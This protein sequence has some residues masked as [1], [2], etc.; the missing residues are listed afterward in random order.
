MK[1]F[2]WLTIF[3]ALIL[4]G[5]GKDD[6]PEVVPQIPDVETTSY[7]VSMHG[8]LAVDGNKIVNKN[9]TPV[10]FAG[11]SFFWSNDGWGGEYYYKASVVSW[12]KK[13]W[14]STIV[15]VAMGVDDDGGYLKNKAA[16]L[17]RVKTIVDAAI[18]ED[19]YVIIDWHSH[20]AENYSSDAVAFFKEMATLY[21]KKENVIYE[22][23]NEP[24]DISWSNVIKPYAEKIIAAIRAI[25][26]D[27]LIIV[28]TPVWSQKVDDAASDPITKYSNIAYTLHFYSINHK[29]WLR[30]RASAALSKGIALFVTE[31]GAVGYT[32]N[33]PES[34]LW[35]KWCKE[36]KISHCCWAVNDKAEAWSSLVKG[37]N[38]SGNWSDSQLTETGKYNRKIIRNWEN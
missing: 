20:H 31:W 17:S 36:N 9:G 38:S 37:A 29:Q 3:F 15:R 1:V 4:V 18:K 11:N 5:C 2:S 30:D 13:D 28:G 21:G 23:Y 14:K 16:N 34:D 25:D 7:V 27:N 6:E 10:C 32:Q 19:M 12:L 33:D 22:I 35:M 8:A 26:P 24:L